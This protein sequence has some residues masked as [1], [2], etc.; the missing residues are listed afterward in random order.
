MKLNRQKDK[1][2]IFKWLKRLF[3]GVFLLEL[4]RLFLKEEKFKQIKENLKEFAREEEKEVEELA[5]GKEG[6]GRFFR[7]CGSIFK[8]FFIPGKGNDHKPKILRA[9]SLTIIAAFLILIKVLVSGYLFLIYPNSAEMS[10][11]ISDEIITLTNQSREENGLPALK[12]NSVLSLSAKRKAED[13]LAY[14]Y[15]AHQSPNGYMPWNWIE[16]IQYAYFYAGENLAMNFSSAASAHR[17]LMQSAS[18]K[19]NILNERY[20]DIGVAVVSGKISG[21]ETNLLVEFFASRK[22]SSLA[23]TA[24]VKTQTP[25]PAPVVKPLAEAK[26][27]PTEVLPTENRAEVK[28]SETKEPEK[29]AALTNPPAE[30]PL[31]LQTDELSG[32]NSVSQIEVYPAQE[33]GKIKTA[34]Q[35]I[36]WSKYIFLA[37]L[38][39]MIIALL[40]NIFIKISVQHKPVII[41]SLLVIILIAGLLSVKLHL[42]ESVIDKVFVI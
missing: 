17:A 7:D 22:T 23:T 11:T 19:K 16:R 6:F 40:L 24:T 21:K 2:G 1:K 30:E 15:F 12:V 8:D 31:P 41:Q 42:L 38:V 37:A 39:F 26:P 14:D 3:I 28:S 25:A 33:E 4:F 29:T 27:A 20:E 9:K 13:M 35:L 18:H 10:A 5:E 34:D 36:N 32:N